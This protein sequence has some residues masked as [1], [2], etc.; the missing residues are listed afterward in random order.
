VMFSLLT[1]LELYV[2]RAQRPQCFESSPFC[3][4][5]LSFALVH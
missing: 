2:R 3:G 5:F 4:S 1:A